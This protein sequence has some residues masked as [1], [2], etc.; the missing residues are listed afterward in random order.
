MGEIVSLDMV[1]TRV[2]IHVEAGSVIVQ[3]N[4]EQ[5][6]SLDPSEA[7]D[8]GGNIAEAGRMAKRNPSISKPFSEATRKRK[9]QSKGAEQEYPDN[10]RRGARKSKESS[11]SKENEDE[12]RGGNKNSLINGPM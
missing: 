12:W 3:Y 2:D 10:K 5:V 4:G 6:R 9:P 11:E 7:I 1:K 8:C